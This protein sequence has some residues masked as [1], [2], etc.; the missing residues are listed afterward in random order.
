MKKIISLL[1][2]SVFMQSCAQNSN[3]NSK[4]AI[5]MDD[6]KTF[7][8]E[9]QYRLKISGNLSYEVRV[10]DIPIAVRNNTGSQTLWFPINNTIAK[11]GL[12]SLEINVFPKL[13]KNGA[14]FEK[15]IGAGDFEL[16]VEQ[17]AWSKAGGLDKPKVVL[18]YDLPET[19]FSKAESHKDILSFNA[20]VPYKLIAWNDGKTFNLKDSEVLKKKV[21]SAYNDL[22][23]DYETQKGKQFTD[24]AS[25][26]LFNLYQASYFTKE[27]G[28][29]YVKAIVDFV[30]EEPTKLEPLENY[31]L[32]ICGGGKLIGLKRTDGYNNN[33]GVL[34]RVYNEGGQK[35]QID[36][37]LLYQPADQNELEVIF[38]MNVVKPAQP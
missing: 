24:R 30:N 18:R 5:K 27:E 35:V 10:N 1:I 23:T 31:K 4:Q 34:R 33:E 11:S 17:T 32:I 7:E 22:K 13:E 38:Y 12:Q 36:D 6:L 16:M 25:K 37:I 15:F 21:L 14:K 28:Q 20:T 2:I 3:T 8:N 19:D 9:P 29:E 26:G